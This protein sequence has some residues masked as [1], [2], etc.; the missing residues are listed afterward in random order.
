MKEPMAMMHFT[1]RLNWCMFITFLE[2]FI[3]CICAWLEIINLIVLY[4]LI[5]PRAEKVN[6]FSIN[7]VLHSSSEFFS[8]GHWNTKYSN[9]VFP[10]YIFYFQ[11][12]KEVN[13]QHKMKSIEVL[14]VLCPIM[15]CQHLYLSFP[16]LF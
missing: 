6:F 7:I 15:F 5:L 14:D 11:A 2:N 10:R 12:K 1:K 4:S 16:C 8:K 13:G 9:T 3:L